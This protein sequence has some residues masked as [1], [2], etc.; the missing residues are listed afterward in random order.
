ME[1]VFVQTEEGIETVWAMLTPRRLDY[2]LQ[3]I[4]RICIASIYI[5]PRSQMKSQTMDHIIQS[6]HVIRARYDNN[7]NFILAGDVNRTN[8]QDVLDSYGA[9]KQCVTVGT[10]KEATLEII[11]SDLT[12]LSHPPTVFGP[13]KVDENKAGKDSDHNIVVFAP[14]SNAKFKVERKKKSIKIRP[15]PESSI[16]S[17]ATE[18]QNQQWHEVINELDQG[19]WLVPDP[20]G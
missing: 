9:L 8:Y 5:A 18:I 13:Q 15:I 7:V 20:I 2:K 17:F 1:Q 14:R 19:T 12:N 4:K 11:L 10:R 3:Q 6:I 16:P